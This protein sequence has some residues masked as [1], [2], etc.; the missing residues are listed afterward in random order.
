MSHAPRTV[1][2]FLELSRRGYY[3]MPGQL[4]SGASIRV[5]PCNPFHGEL[6]RLLLIGPRTRA[7]CECTPLTALRAAPPANGRVWCSDTRVRDLGP[8]AS[9]MP[10][11]AWGRTPAS[12]SAS[13][14]ASAPAPASAFA[15]V[16]SGRALTRAAT[17]AAVAAAASPTAQYGASP[18]AQ[19]GAPPTAQ[20][21]A[22][23]AAAAAP[24]RPMPPRLP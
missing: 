24:Q 1:Q 12:A 17:A 14:S 13:A 22:S 10:S 9:S 2:N 6:L 5:V 8:R 19:Y 23:H 21:G 4:H 18:T 11:L 16:L 7:A 20:Y 3:D 15:S